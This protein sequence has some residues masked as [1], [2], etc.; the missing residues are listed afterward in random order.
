[1]MPL[2]VIIW[3]SM[4]IGAVVAFAAYMLK[5]YLTGDDGGIW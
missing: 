3:M 5:V 2:Q 1:M 4:A